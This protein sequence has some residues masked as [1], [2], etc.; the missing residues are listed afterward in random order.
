MRW[1]MG[2]VVVG[3]LAVLGYQYLGPESARPVERAVLPTEETS[4]QPPAQKS[5][6]QT[7][8]GEP[9][10]VSDRTK[11]LEDE[12]AIRAKQVAAETAR[13][14]QAAAER[15]A[16]AAQ[17]VASSGVGLEIGGADLG[18]GVAKAVDELTATLGTITD[19]AS[20]QA[21]VPKLVAI[22]A[23]LYVLKPKIAQLPDDARKNLASLVTGMLPQVQSATARVQATPG[24]GA[25][26]KPALDPIMTKLDAWSEAPA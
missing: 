7:A 8:A 17:D 22:D 11:A 21:A 24:A 19:Q 15:V 10:A 20:A 18:K 6:D 26:V 14:L 2:I 16:R 23:R 1:V 12:V 4:R 25:V 9:A 5:G 3:A 13:K